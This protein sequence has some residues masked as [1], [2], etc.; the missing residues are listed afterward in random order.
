MLRNPHITHV[1]Y[2]LVQECD[3]L[4]N[5][6]S[7]YHSGN[8]LV[9]RGNFYLTSDTEPVKEKAEEESIVVIEIRVLARPIRFF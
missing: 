8:L 3:V 6:D 1:T 7:S 9:V 5:M 2:V 4:G